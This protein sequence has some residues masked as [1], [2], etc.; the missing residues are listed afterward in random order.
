MNPDT[1]LPTRHLKAGTSIAQA[2][3]WQYEPVTLASPA[4]EVMTDLTQFKAASAMPSI[5]LEQAEQKMIY[6]GVRTL[7]VVED[8]PKIL[9]LV[10]STDLQGD[11]PLRLI[12]ERRLARDRIMIADVMTPLADLDAIDFDSLR[13]ASVSNLVATLKRF[14]RSHLLVVES[15]AEGPERVRGV[16]SRAQIERQL[17]QRLEMTEVATNF[18]ELGKMLS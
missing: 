17:G 1:V 4:L 9:G 12:E 15:P 7:F 16:I 18:A 14:G 2:H 10:T 5:S 3:P 8:M 13:F 11:K 6:L